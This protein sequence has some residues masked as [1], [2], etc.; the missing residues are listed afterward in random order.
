MIVTS[1]LESA[2]SRSRHNGDRLLETWLCRERLAMDIAFQW[3][4]I[5]C[6]VS[7]RSCKLNDLQCH[8]VEIAMTSSTRIL[9]YY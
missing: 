2:S 9:K 4:T 3:N 7:A 8:L 1:P 6:E 5:N